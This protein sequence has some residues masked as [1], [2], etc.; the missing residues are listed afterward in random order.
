[1]ANESNLF[2]RYKECRRIESEVQKFEIY[3][4]NLQ[5]ETINYLYFDS[6]GNITVTISFGN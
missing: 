1:M 2:S 5:L 4:P 3:F 6:Y